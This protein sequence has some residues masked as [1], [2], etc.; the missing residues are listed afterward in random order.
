M[1]WSN[2]LFFFLT[3]SLLPC[4]MFLLNNSILC[5]CHHHYFPLLHLFADSVVWTPYSKVKTSKMYCTNISE[6]CTVTSLACVRLWME[7]FRSNPFRVTWS[8]R[9]FHSLKQLHLYFSLLISI[10][11]E[12]MSHTVDRYMLTRLT[13]NVSVF[14]DQRKHWNKDTRQKL[15]PYP[16]LLFALCIMSNCLQTESITVTCICLSSVHIW[17]TVAQSAW[18]TGVARTQQ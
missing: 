14:N 7:Y 1:F 3:L 17:T 8:K 16:V 12:S 4:T 6:K 2:F 5:L 15:F 18:T 11:D 9:C 10:D 13:V